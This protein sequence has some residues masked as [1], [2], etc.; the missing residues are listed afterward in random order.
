MRTVILMILLLSSVP[1]YSTVS[2]ETKAIELKGDCES[3]QSKSLSFPLKVYIEGNTVFV[4]FYIVMT[5]ATIT[6]TSSEGETESRT[7]SFTESQTEAFYISQG[8][9]HITITTP[10]GTNLYGTFFIE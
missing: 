6:L 1:I 9:Y 8:M 5:D 7:I 10:R 2:N 3:P 4:Q